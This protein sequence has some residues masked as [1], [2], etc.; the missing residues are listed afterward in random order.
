M[1]FVI[2]KMSV[3]L[4]KTA[5]PL[6]AKS[7]IYWRKCLILVP[8]KLWLALLAA[9]TEGDERR[10]PVGRLFGCTQCIQEWANLGT[11]ALSWLL[12]TWHHSW[13]LLDFFLSGTL[14]LGFWK[15]DDKNICSCA[16]CHGNLCGTAENEVASVFTKSEYL[17]L[18]QY[19]CI[20]ICKCVMV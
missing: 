5:S 13:M 12:T 6:K 15:T 7:L 10:T 8:T 11:T 18:R 4:N 17:S 9:N 3:N 16:L 2:S 19:S 14:S 20:S 1:D